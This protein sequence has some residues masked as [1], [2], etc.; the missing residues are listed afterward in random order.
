MHTCSKCTSAHSSLSCTVIARVGCCTMKSLPFWPFIH[1][2]VSRTYWSL[3]GASRQHPPPSQRRMKGRKEGREG[4]GEGEKGSGEG[5]EVGRGERRG[6]GDFRCPNSVVHDVILRSP[7]HGRRYCG[8]WR[9]ALRQSHHPWTRST[10]VFPE[11]TSRRLSWTF[12]SRRRLPGSTTS[13]RGMQVGSSR[14][15]HASFGKVR[16]PD[17][18]RS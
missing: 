9:G 13:S 7:G 5:V 16:V 11:R 8:E 15:L 2:N 17:Q 1:N 6:R 14:A 4:M 10:S 12:W 3:M 18:A